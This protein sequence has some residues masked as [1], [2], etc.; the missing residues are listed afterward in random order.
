MT[1]GDQRGDGVT[2]HRHQH[3]GE[4]TGVTAGQVRDGE[5]TDAHQAEPQAG[6][7]AGAETLRVAEEPGERHTDDGDA[8]DQQ[9]GGG[10][11]EVAFRGGQGVPG[12]DDLDDREG[13]QGAPVGADGPGETSLP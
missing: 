5:D 12:A 4:R 7:A 3:L 11:G 2:Q 6:E 13:Q 9:A 8:R 1:G 10:A